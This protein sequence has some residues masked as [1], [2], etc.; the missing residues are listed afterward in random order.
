MITDGGD[1]TLTPTNFGNGTTLTFADAGDSVI[2]EFT[3][4]AWY[5]LSNNGVAVA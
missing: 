1:G 2:L 4:S 3:N 5:I